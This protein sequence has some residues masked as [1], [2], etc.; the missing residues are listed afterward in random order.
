MVWAMM[1][2]SKHRIIIIFMINM[3][4]LINMYTYIS[5]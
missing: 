3:N 1:M 2:E 5:R 4:Y